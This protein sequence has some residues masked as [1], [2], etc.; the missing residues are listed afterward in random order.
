MNFDFFTKLTTIQQVILLLSVITTICVVL[1][2][3]RLL[4]LKAIETLTGGK[5][6][7][8]IH[9]K[10]RHST[11]DSTPKLVVEGETTESPHLDCPHVADVI[12][13]LHSQ[14]LM[15][16]KVFH[17]R[18]HDILRNQMSY[19]ENKVDMVLN[20]N[21]INFSIL[22]KNIGK[23]DYLY[24]EEYIAYK[25]LLEYNREKILTK[26]RHMCKENHFADKTEDD[27]NEYVRNNI[28]IITDMLVQQAK[29]FFPFYLSLPGY[30]DFVEATNT[31]MNSYILDI[32]YNARD[33]SF[34]SIAQ[35]EQLIDEFEQ[36]YENTIGVKP[37]RIVV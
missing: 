29:S 24:S 4:A 22:L 20:A 33:V 19:A 12:L 2:Y 9:I 8:N 7:Y 34:R 15:L 10:S 35:V 27:F 36:E 32:L 11:K 30:A 21:E 6:D 18:D 26:F 37:K 3:I 17:I 1:W 16:A 14:Q 25:S 31:K 5:L 23:V 28:T 13:L